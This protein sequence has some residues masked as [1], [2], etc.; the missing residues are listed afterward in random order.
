MTNPTFAEKPLFEKIGAEIITKLRTRD[1]KCV[2]WCSKLESNGFVVVNTN[3]FQELRNSVP[4]FS[5]LNES[6]C[7]LNTYYG[8]EVITITTHLER[9][10]LSMIPKFSNYVQLLDEQGYFI[11]EKL[12]T[13]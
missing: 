11:K 1:E 3:I 13:R 5:I 12:C 7:Y 10:L 2:D 8:L 9:K 4:S 6:I